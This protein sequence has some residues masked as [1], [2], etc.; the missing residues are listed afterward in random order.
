MKIQ[1]SIL[2]KITILADK[3]FIFDQK[4]LENSNIIDEDEKDSI[5]FG[6]NN[7]ILCLVSPVNYSI[8][9]EKELSLIFEKIQV[10]G[11]NEQT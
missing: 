7:H 3:G 6:L 1:H 8:L 9:P 2:Y 10:P 11:N 5:T 4:L